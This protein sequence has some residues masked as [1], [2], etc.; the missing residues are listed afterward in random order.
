MPD[1]LSDTAENNVRIHGFLPWE[2]TRLF[3]K[4][5]KAAS[6]AEGVK[7]LFF[8]RKAMREFRAGRYLAERGVP[9]PTILAVG[10]ERRGSRAVLVFEEVTDAPSVHELLEETSID[11]IPGLLE[12]LSDITV[13]LHDADFYHRDYH[14]GNLLAPSLGGVED[15]LVID[16]HRS[17]H[18][19]SMSGR[20]GLENIADL[21]Q[22]VT[23]GGDPSII[24]RFLER[25][26]ERRRDLSWGLSEGQKYV[27]R[28]IA[29]RERRRLKSRTKR[30]FKNSTDYFTARSSEWIFFGRREAFGDAGR[31]PRVALD[32]VTALIR[33][34]DEGGGDV[35][36]DD[37]K[38]RV[39]L[40]PGR[41]GEVCVKAYERLS[42]S[43]CIRGLVKLSR[44]QR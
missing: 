3:V 15:L 13:T 39:I 33:R 32:E 6:T 14:I 24:R 40:L 22:S 7:A 44:G 34:L 30:C 28:R 8:G 1:V 37:R 19:R 36:K 26:Q 10:V 41:D 4:L 9:M 18:P 29:A 21:L 12:G 42:L 17:S 25:Y 20:R 31:D 16:L 38:A 23:P 2:G 43:E 35:V 11:L 5:F 27:T